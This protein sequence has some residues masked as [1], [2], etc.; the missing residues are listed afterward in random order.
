M[1]G[2]GPSTCRGGVESHGESPTTEAH[3]V[4]PH[5][6][7]QSACGSHPEYP[8]AGVNRGESSTMDAELD[9]L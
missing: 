6:C 9:D 5:C 3:V 1:R 8:H 4:P 2:G 7:G